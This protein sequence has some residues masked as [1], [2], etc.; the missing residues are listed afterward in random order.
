MLRA[1]IAVFALAV[2]APLT[3][4]GADAAPAAG[5]TTFQAGAFGNVWLHNCRYTATGP[6]VYQ[7]LTFNHWKISVNRNGEGF[8][9]IV[10]DGRPVVQLMPWDRGGASIWGPNSG[11]IAT[12]PG[13]IVDVSIYPD[14]YQ[15]CKKEE[16]NTFCDPEKDEPPISLPFA[17]YL[18]AHD[19]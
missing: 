15:M 1:K 3:F 14:P 9:T 19:A 5:C 17:G 12:L 6:G 11:T 13:D 7:A 8:K 4:S 16:D 10:A 18:E 2:A